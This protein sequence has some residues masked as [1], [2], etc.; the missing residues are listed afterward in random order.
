MR[1]IFGIDTESLPVPD[2]EKP[3]RQE[4]LHYYVPYRLEDST[5]RIFWP[6]GSLWMTT[7]AVPNDL[8]AVQNFTL[9]SF[10]SLEPSARNFAMATWQTTGTTEIPGT[11][12]LMLTDEELMI[13]FLLE[14][15]ECETRFS[16]RVRPVL[17]A[18]KCPPFKA[19]MPVVN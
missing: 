15:S 6:E 11:Q 19:F 12:T 14:Y 18:G 13:L 17:S 2:L 4:P 3:Q 1:T 8:E 10:W 9:R 16:S 5:L 7:E